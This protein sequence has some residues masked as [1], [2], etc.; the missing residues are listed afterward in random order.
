[1]LYACCFL[2]LDEQLRTINQE[3]IPQE[4]AYGNTGQ[5]DGDVG[6]HQSSYDGDS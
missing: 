2:T 4:F 6:S 1:M 5:R 3:H